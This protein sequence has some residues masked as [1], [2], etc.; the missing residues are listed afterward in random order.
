MTDEMREDLKEIGKETGRTG[1][2]ILIATLLIIASTALSMKNKKE[3]KKI[4]ESC[5]RLK[6]KLTKLWDN[7]SMYTKRKFIRLFF[8]AIKEEKKIA[9]TF[10][11]LAGT[12]LLGFIALAKSKDKLKDASI[13]MKMTGNRMKLFAEEY[14]FSDDD[15]DDDDDEI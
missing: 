3:A 1:V 5:K 9:L 4:I 10:L 7:R 11:A 2:D 8:R 12:A 6:R 14:I 15:D 13:D